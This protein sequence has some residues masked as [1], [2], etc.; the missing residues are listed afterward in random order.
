MIFS[1][2]SKLYGSK[3]PLQKVGRWNLI[4]KITKHNVQIPT[5]CWQRYVWNMLGFSWWPL[6]VWHDMLNMTWSGTDKFT[7]KQCHQTGWFSATGT[8][9]VTI[10]LAT[11][12]IF[13][14][15]CVD[16]QA[17]PLIRLDYTPKS[18][19]WKN[20]MLLK[21]VQ[22]TSCLWVLAVTSLFC[23][24]IVCTERN[25]RQKMQW[26]GPKKTSKSFVHHEWCGH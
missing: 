21:I 6:I 26:L 7:P 15:W 20:E 19:T 5:R 18:S 2:Q 1:Y 16:S 24:W 4:S 10:V 11:F 23:N 22:Q 13:L 14:A 3:R 17:T 9:G 8:A 25:Q 12:P